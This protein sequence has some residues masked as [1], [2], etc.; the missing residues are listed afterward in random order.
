MMLLYFFMKVN[1]FVTLPFANTIVSCKQFMH[2]YNWKGRAQV[3]SINRLMCN[4]NTREPV[5]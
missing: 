1:D 5:E 4:T 2:T 3:F